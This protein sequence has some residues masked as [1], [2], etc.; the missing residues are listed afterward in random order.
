VASTGEGIDHLLEELDRHAAWLAESG[1]LV[2]R[3][4]LRARGEVEAV[5]LAA[6]RERWGSAGT[7]PDLDALAE[8]VSRGD[9]DPYAAADEL[10]G[11]AS[12]RD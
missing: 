6:L 4:T 11:E 8:R 5:A 12:G 9:L 2:R 10:L 3:R 1:E 7:G